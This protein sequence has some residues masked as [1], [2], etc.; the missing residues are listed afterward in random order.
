M[1]FA[2]NFDTQLQQ[3]AISSSPLQQ[4]VKKNYL[5]IQI[6]TWQLK[7]NIKKNEENIKKRIKK[8]YLN[9]LVK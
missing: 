6:G 5:F 9:E 7:E 4:G 2:I 8:E 1:L 3:A